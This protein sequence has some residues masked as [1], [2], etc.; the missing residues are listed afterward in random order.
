MS[1]EHRTTSQL[2]LADQSGIKKVRRLAA[3]AMAV[4]VA[5]A[6]PAVAVAASMASAP[7]ARCATGP[8]NGVLRDL[9][10]LT[11]PDGL[12]LPRYSAFGLSDLR[13]ERAAG[14]PEDDLE[15]LR[16]RGQELKGRLAELRFGSPLGPVHGDAHTDNLMVDRSGVVHL[17]TFSDW[18]R[19]TWGE[20][21]SGFGEAAVDELGVTLDVGKPSAEGAGE[22]VGVGECGVGHRPAP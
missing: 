2:E 8:G 4:T 6:T 5:V 16:K 12:E 14:I 11:L 19:G 22:V 3:I 18:L 21:Q 13:L 10:A 9:H 15:F 20:G 1:P 7:G 17:L